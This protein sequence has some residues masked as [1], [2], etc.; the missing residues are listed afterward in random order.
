LL[1]TACIGQNVYTLKVGNPQRKRYF[2]IVDWIH[3][4]QNMDQWSAPVI[5][6][7]K[8]TLVDE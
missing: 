7:W 1:H 2:Q 5:C 4:G 3:L 8:I 6:V